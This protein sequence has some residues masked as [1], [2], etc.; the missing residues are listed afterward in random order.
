MAQEAA[1]GPKE[2]EDFDGSDIKRL[3][4]NESNFNKYIDKTFNSLDTHHKGTLSKKELMPV[5]ENLGQS[6]GLPPHG[7][8]K[9][10]DHIYDEVFEEFNNENGVSKETFA[11]VLREV[12]LGLADGLERDP[13]SV[14]QLDGSTLRKYAETGM[15]E[16]D[17]VATF[18]RL[19]VNQDNSLPATKLVD[20]LNGIPVEKGM[21]P[22]DDPKMKEVLGNAL[23][24]ANVDTGDRL[25][26]FQFAEALKKIVLV[27]ANGMSKTPVEV[28]HSENVFDGK[29][30]VSFLKDK[31]NFQTALDAT[32]EKLP[33]DKKGRCR[34]DYLRVGIDELCP[35][36]GLPPV[37][38]VDEMD[39]VM[40]TVFSKIDL[41]HE[42]TVS[43][44]EFDK[45]MLEALGSLMLQLE[46][47]PIAINNS[48]ILEDSAIPKVASSPTST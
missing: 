44:Q 13:I 8:D 9:E 32:W 21:P 35:A 7:A 2:V 43:K 28:A 25:D 39:S 46:G 47:K 33:K 40:K 38:S 27:I 34:K 45:T 24:S 31:E 16:A 1:S 37:G 15:F 20:A 10:S 14:L 4:G 17:V 11:K 26:Q 5:M 48:R 19:D 3:V 22:A 23:A 12:F 36:A 42:E 30:I 29:G 41:N 18:T 6:L